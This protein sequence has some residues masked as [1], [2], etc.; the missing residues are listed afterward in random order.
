[1][2]LNNKLYDV[3]KWVAQYLLPGLAAL[4]FALSGVWGLP[5]PEEIVGS[6]VAL[7]VF[8]GTILGISTI[9][10]NKAQQTEGFMATTSMSADDYES[11]TS[12]SLDG[13]TY[14]ILKWTT[15]I[16]LPAFGTLYFAFSRY[17]GLPY[18]EEIVG[19]VAA[20]TAFSGVLLGVSTNKFKKS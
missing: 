11:S 17:W 15:M 3:L 9:K 19:T 6:I 7:D 2:F 5:Y 1:M 16:V 4:Y 20:L 12:G 13:N 8:L 14:E 10:Y 18:G